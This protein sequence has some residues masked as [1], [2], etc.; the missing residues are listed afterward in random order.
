M[1]D[2]IKFSRF[3]QSGLKQGEKEYGKYNFLKE[4]N[5]KI[6]TDIQEE[7][8]DIANYSYMLWYKI[9]KMKKRLENE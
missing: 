5:D 8:R 4:S 7:C 9:E 2:F 1:K 3:M 6:L